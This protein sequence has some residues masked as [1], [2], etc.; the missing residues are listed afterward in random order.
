MPRPKTD[1]VWPPKLPQGF[2]LTV[3]ERGYIKRMSGVVRWIAGKVAPE[4]ALAIYHRKAAAESR[5]VVPLPALLAPTPAPTNDA[6]VHWMLGRY[7]VDRKADLDRGDLKTEA[8]DQIRRACRRCDDIIAD[9]RCDLISPDLIRQL[10]DRLSAD[11]KSTDA[12]RRTIG[13]FKAA[14]THAVEHDWI[15]PVR[16]GRPGKFGGKAPPT[17][18]WRLFTADD[19]ARILAEIEHRMKNRPSDGR[20]GYCWHQLKAGVLL[21]MNGGMG[22]KELSELTV[23]VVDLNRGIIDH[24]RGKTGK[25]HVVPLWPETI[26]ALRFVLNLRGGPDDLV[27]KNRGGGSWNYSE[28]RV[29]KGKLRKFSDDNFKARMNEVL[30]TIGLKRDGE[31]FYKLKHTF[32]TAASECLDSD[33]L[34]ILMGHTL[35]VRG[36]YVRIS[37]ERLRAVVTHVRKVLLDR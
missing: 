18:K 7:L 8:F 3:T 24:A 32:S 16:M 11:L 30:K 28:M 19:I 6:T 34:K 5:G 33:A 21:A 31:S 27:F 1:I 37:E 17:M 23:G 22:S 14:C 2:P 25:Q 26:D 9:T 20:I 29:A 15:A 13:V 10:Y 36:H 4:E 12:A 35:G